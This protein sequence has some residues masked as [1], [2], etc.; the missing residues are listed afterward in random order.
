VHLVG[1]IIRNLYVPGLKKKKKNGELNPRHLTDNPTLQ[2][3]AFSSIDREISNAW[4]KHQ[5]KAKN[6]RTELVLSTVLCV[7]VRNVIRA[8]I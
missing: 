6:K 5:N 7:F 1:F 3:A 4:L 2:D 8:N